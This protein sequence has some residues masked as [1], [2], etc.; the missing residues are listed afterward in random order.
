[1]VSL[2]VTR[3]PRR[4]DHGDKEIR[5]APARLVPTA[6]VADPGASC[7]GGVL[8]ST[9]HVTGLSPELKVAMV[10]VRDGDGREYTLVHAGGTT[11][12]IAPGSPSDAFRGKPAGGDWTIS[13]PLQPGESCDP[14]RFPNN[15][16]V[17]V[18][19]QC[20]AD[21]ARR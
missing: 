19:P 10:E 4:P 13:T 6:S 7:T 21:G 2:H 11:G 12:H 14:P 8:T 15:L 3:W 9:A 20:G 5:V 16:A 1:M 18:H 17:V